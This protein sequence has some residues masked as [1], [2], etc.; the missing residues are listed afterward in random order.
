MRKH[1]L[2]TPLILLL[3]AVLGA[4]SLPFGGAG[5]TPPPA[6][7]AANQEQSAPTAYAAVPADSVE[8][9][10][11]SE[12]LPDSAVSVVVLDLPDSLRGQS[13]AEVIAAYRPRMARLGATWVTLYR[14]G[15]QHWIAGYYVPAGVRTARAARAGTPA[16]DRVSSP[17]A[18]TGSGSVHVRGYYRRDGTYVRPHTRSRPRSRP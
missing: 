10:D 14:K 17:P 11:L 1:P 9:H 12:P 18:S 4:C 3:C 8:V 7:Q 5:W 2:L 16:R 15:S 13:D 6:A